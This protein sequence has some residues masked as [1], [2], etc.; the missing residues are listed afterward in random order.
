[1]RPT[2]TEMEALKEKTRPVWELFRNRLGQDLIDMV[3]R[4]QQ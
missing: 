1:M 4:T 3:V 2:P